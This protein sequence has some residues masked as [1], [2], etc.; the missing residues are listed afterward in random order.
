VGFAGGMRVLGE[1]LGNYFKMASVLL[2]LRILLSYMC[3]YI[4]IYENVFNFCNFMKYSNVT[5]FMLFCTVI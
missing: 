3:I 2:F 4:Y 5:Y 1:I